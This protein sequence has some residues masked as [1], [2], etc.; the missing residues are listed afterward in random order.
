[1]VFGNFC[2]RTIEF[3]VQSPRQDT[4]PHSVIGIPQ[5]S[6]DID[7]GVPLKIVKLFPLIQHSTLCRYELCFH[8]L[9]DP[10]P[11]MSLLPHKKPELKRNVVGQY[12]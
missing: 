2:E 6:R 12:Q 11:S 1:M 9:N 8:F 4:R 3:P 10:P 7:P 5:L